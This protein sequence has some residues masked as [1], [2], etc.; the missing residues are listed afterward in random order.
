MGITK[1]NLKKI[2]QIF[3][4]TKENGTGLGVSLSKDIIE[5]HGGSMKYSSKV[6]KGTKVTL[7]LPRKN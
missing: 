6:G 2:T 3:Y 5:G 7:L 1:D 4:T